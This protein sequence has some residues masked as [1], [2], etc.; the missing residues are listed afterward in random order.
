MIT[1]TGAYTI[2]NFKDIT[3][4]IT[5]FSAFISTLIGVP[6]P[7]LVKLTVT[8]ALVYKVA[9][10]TSNNLKVTLPV[11]TPVCV[12]RN[13]SPKTVREVSTLTSNNLSSLPRGN[14]I[15]AAVQTVYKR[16]RGH[17]C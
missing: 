1:T 10:S 3:T 2:I 16:A 4:R 11:L 12:T 9:N 7:P 15:I 6:K 13:L 8:I 14:C 17:S 5:T